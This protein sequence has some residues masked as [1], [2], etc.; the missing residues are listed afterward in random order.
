MFMSE[1]SKS[2]STPQIRPLQDDE[3][4]SVSGGFFPLLVMA[5][6]VGFDAGFIGVMA[7]GDLD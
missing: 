7:F 1:S 5:F 2:E 6:A 4:N 3:V